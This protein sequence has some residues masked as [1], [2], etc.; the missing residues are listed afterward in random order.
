MAHV[1]VVDD[2]EDLTE[3]LALLLKLWGHQPEVAASGRAALA[4]ARARRPDVVL[5]DLGLPDLSGYE[6]ARRL[7]A[8]HGPDATM[9]VALSGRDR[10]DCPCCREAAFDHHYVKPVDPLTLRD[11]LARSA[12]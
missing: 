6:V 4:A 3:A 8:L 5:L 7:R 9:L 11:L 10:E 1:L 12:P 2:S